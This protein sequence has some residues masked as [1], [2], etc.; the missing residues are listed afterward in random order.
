MSREDSRGRTPAQNKGGGGLGQNG[1]ANT[2]GRWREREEA[3]GGVRLH[4]G[5]WANG[6]WVGL[7]GLARS[8]MKIGFWIFA[9]IFSINAE[10]RNKLEE[11]DR[12]LRKC[13]ILPGCRLDYLE[14]LS[15]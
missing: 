11:I 5:L 8:E 4:C 12:G 10:T 9:L 1:G 14:Q 15:Y 7:T 13:E 3:D 2:W 6:R